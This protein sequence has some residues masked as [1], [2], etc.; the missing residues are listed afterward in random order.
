[1]CLPWA[2]QPARRS[3]LK[4]LIPPSHVGWV[5]DPAHPSKTKPALTPANRLRQETCRGERR[6]EHR[7]TNNEHRSEERDRA[8]SILRGRG[9]QPREP[10]PRD[11]PS[12]PRPRRRCRGRRPRLKQSTLLHKALCIRICKPAFGVGIPAARIQHLVSRIQN[13]VSCIPHPLRQIETTPKR[14]RPVELVAS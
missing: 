13:P 8:E 10:Q 14:R 1:M 3:A 9:F 12:K 4:Q 6:S 7:T 11:H 5:S 2:R